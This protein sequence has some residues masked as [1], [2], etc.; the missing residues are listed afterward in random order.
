V[1]F[2]GIHSHEIL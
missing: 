1:Y 2:W